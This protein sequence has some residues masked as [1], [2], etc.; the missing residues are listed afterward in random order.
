MTISSYF[1]FLGN[2]TQLIIGFG[3]LWCFDF[4]LTKKI[5]KR[6]NF[7]VERRVKDKLTKDRVFKFETHTLE[8]KIL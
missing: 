6:F 7:F 8:I 3:N 1:S 4:S 2:T 5:L